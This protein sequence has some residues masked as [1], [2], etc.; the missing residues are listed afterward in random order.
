MYQQYQDRVGFLFVYI[1]EAHPDDEWQL[2]SNTEDDVVFDQPITFGMRQDVAQQ[3]SAALSLTM[4]CVVDDMG[5]SVDN[6]YAGW[7]ERLFVVD[8]DGRIAYSGGQGPF[9][10]EPDEVAA[11]LGENVGPP[12]Q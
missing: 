8:A 9:N 7:P 2:D 6:A 3:C 1:Q 10:F 4:P 11:W 12:A 5:N